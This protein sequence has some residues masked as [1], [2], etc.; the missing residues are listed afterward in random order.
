MQYFMK[1]GPTGDFN[2]RNFHDIRSF[3][4]SP[5]M[6]RYLTNMKHETA[7]IFKTNSLRKSYE[8]RSIKYGPGILY[9]LKT[10]QWEITT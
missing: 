1:P 2:R 10:A 9:L 8:I 5:V 7:L 3:K 4:Y 6:Q